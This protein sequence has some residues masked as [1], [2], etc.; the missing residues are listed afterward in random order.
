MLRNSRG[1][2]THYKDSLIEG[3][4]TIAHVRCFD[5][6]TCGR[7]TWKDLRPMIWTC[8][9]PRAFS[10]GSNLMVGQVD[11]IHF[12][13]CGFAFAVLVIQTTVHGVGMYCRKT[14][15]KNCRLPQWM[16]SS[17]RAGCIT[18]A[19]CEKNIPGTSYLF[20]KVKSDPFQNLSKPK[21]SMG[22]DYLPYMN[23]LNVW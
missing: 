10:M 5:P 7:K 12:I 9:C 3:G 17:K 2:Y 18:M 16:Q 15:A 6:G 11:V 8:F 4:M 13:C 19:P 22:L 1:L 23:G 14:M 21:C 20:G